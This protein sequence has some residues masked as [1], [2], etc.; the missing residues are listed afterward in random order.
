MNYF[1]LLKNEISL[2]F[3]RKFENIVATVK[4]AI[5]IYGSKEEMSRKDVE[6]QELQALE[7]IIKS[8]MA[9]AKEM[10][11]AQIADL[12]LKPQEESKDGASQQPIVMS[13]HVME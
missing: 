5:K 8:Q 1:L 13:Q 2:A 7:K 3:L 6:Q 9:I 11:P 4:A 12:G 10:Q